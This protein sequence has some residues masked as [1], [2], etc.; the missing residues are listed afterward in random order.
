MKDHQVLES[1]WLHSIEPSYKV[2]VDGAVFESQKEVS[3]GVVIRDH[4]GNFISGLSKKL[5]FPLGA[6]EIEAKAFETRMIFAGDIGIQDFV[7]EG[8]SLILVRALC[9]TSPALASIAHA[10]YGVRAASYE[11]RNVK[12]SHVRRKGNVPTYILAKQ[13]LYFDDFSVWIEKSPCSIEQALLYDVS[14]TFS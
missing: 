8:D 7:L 2:N 9:D 5:Q 10:I 11:F 13:A 1:K 12:F 4:E 3:V 6:V 14:V